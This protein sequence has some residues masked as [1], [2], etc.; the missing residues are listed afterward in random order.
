MHGSTTPVP[1]TRATYL[2][3]V[4]AP[5][6]GAL[7]LR[8]VE[9]LTEEYADPHA[10]PGA[11]AWQ[12]R[13]ETRALAAVDQLA[14]S[15]AVLATTTLDYTG[16][17]GGVATIGA[18]D[19]TKRLLM[20]IGHEIPDG[21]PL[22]GASFTYDMDP[23]SESYGALASVTT[24]AGGVATIAY[25]RPAL[26]L[27]LRDHAVTPPAEP[28]V[29]YT[30]P[31]LAFGDEYAVA[32]WRGSDGSV[33]ATAYR[34]EGR[35]LAS[36]VLAPPAADA[37]AYAALRIVCGRGCFA[38][39]GATSYTLFHADPGSPGAWVGSA[40]PEPFDLPA[41]APVS[42]AAGAG[43]VALLA[44]VAG[45]MLVRW[46]DG[47]E[48][49]TLR[50]PAPA[51]TK[52]AA[53]DGA[54]GLLVRVASTG[55]RD[56]ELLLVRPDPEAGWVARPFR[57]SESVA[58]LDTLAVAVGSTYAVVTLAG[59][60]D[61]DGT[62]VQAA[63]WWN[64]DGTRV[65]TAT[66]RRVAG[67]R[68]TVA[69]PQVRGATVLLDQDVFRFDGA[70]WR[71]QDLGALTHPGQQAVVALS[72]GAD[73]VA[74]AVR[75]GDGSLV[76]DLIAYDPADTG[77]TPW[78]YVPGMSG[79]PAKPGA[80]VDMTA[81]F[82]PGDPGAASRFVLFDNQLHV[83]SGDGTWPLLL[84]VPTRFT[85]E[86]IASFRLF[87]GY[88][89]YQTDAGVA[90]HP[91]RPGGLGT[92]ADVLLS[93]AKVLPPNGRPTAGE[94]AFAAYTGVWDG[95]HFTLR[96]YRPVAEDVRGALAPLVVSRL[97]LYGNGGPTQT[98]QLPYGAVPIAYEL[99]AATATA[100]GTGRVAAANRA[101]LAPGSAT[102]TD[103]GQGTATSWFFN[104]LSPS[105]PPDRPYP[106]GDDA[107][108]AAAHL[109]RLPGLPYAQAL[110]GAG[111]TA[112][113]LAGTTWWWVTTAA[114]GARTQA[115]YRRP[116]KE[117]RALDGVP[118]ERTFVYH[119]ETG[120]VTRVSGTLPDG[121]ATVTR[122]DY[123]W[124]HYD[125]SRARNL[126]TPVVQAMEDVDGTLVRGTVVT[127]S[128]DWGSGGGQWAPRAT[129]RAVTAQPAAF[130]RWTGDPLPA[131]AGWL[132]EECVAARSAGGIATRTSDALGRVG[133]SVASVDGMR[134]LAAFPN[135]DA[136]GQEAYWYGL[137]PY[138][139]PGPWSY[140]GGGTIAD[141]LVEGEANLGTRSL[142]I[143]YDT[144][145]RAG[146]VAAFQPTD[147]E[148]SYRFS[149]WVQT[150]PSFATDSGAAQLD[151]SAT[152]A[153]P[154][155]H[156]IGSLTVPFPATNGR[157]RYVTAV[158]PLGAWRAEQGVSPD[159]PATVTIAARNQKARTQILLDGL[160]FQPLDAG[161]FA[162]VPD[163]VTGLPL[164]S[165]ETNGATYRLI[166]DANRVVTATVGPDLTVARLAIPSF[167]RLL[168]PD[169]TYAEALPNAT[170][171][172]SA[173]SD[174]VYQNFE[175]SDAGDWTLP[176][177]WSI[178]DGQ[179]VFSGSAVEPPGSA[180][181]LKGFAHDD[182]VATAR[183]VP[184]ATGA[185]P[186]VGI[187]CGNVVALHRASGNDWVLLTRAPGQ[188]WVPSPALPGGL[189]RGDLTFS[190]VG[191]RV[192]V[193]A[194]GRQVFSRLI[195]E[196]VVPDGTLALYLDG[197]GAF[198]DLVALAEPDLRMVMA[199][200]RGLATQ[201]IDL[202]GA[203]VDAFGS[204]GDAVGR[205]A[206]DKNAASVKI[207]SLDER[208]VGAPDDYLPLYDGREQTLEEYLAHG[209][210]SPFVRK[211]HEASPLARLR[212][213]G[214]PGDEL[215]VGGGHSTALA[216]ARNTADGP[217]AGVLPPDTAGNQSLVTI[218]DPDNRDRYRLLA[219]DGRLVAERIPLG[220]TATMTTRHTYDAAGAL[221]ATTPPNGFADPARADAWQ[222]VYTRDF[223]GRATAITTPD[224]GTTR[225]GYDVLGRLRVEQSA[226]QAAATPPVIGYRRYDGLDRLVELG[227]VTGVGW[228]ASVAAVAG[229]PTW[230]GAGTGCKAALTLTYDADAEALGST[231]TEG[232]LV[233]GTRHGADGALA[234]RETS[235]YD[236]AGNV[237][238]RWTEAPGFDAVIRE[239]TFAYDSR[240]Y[241]VL[242]T[243]PKAAA[244]ASPPLTVMYTRDRQGRVVAVG[245]PPPSGFADPLN[246]PPDESA[247]YARFVYDAGG[248]LLTASYENDDPEHPPIVVRY[249]YDTAGWPLATASDV[250]AE[251]VSYFDGGYGGAGSYGGSVAAVA[252]AWQPE[253]DAPYPLLSYTARYAYDPAGRLVAAAPYLAPAATAGLADGSTPITVDPNGNLLTVR[254]GEAT[255]AYRYPQPSG[256]AEGRRPAA[257]SGAA[258]APSNC[259]K[260]VV[261][262]LATSCTFD[263]DP[264]SGWTYGASDAGPGCATVIEGGP[265][266]S[267]HCLRMTGDTLG[268]AAEL[269]YRGYVDPRGRYTMR[270][271]LK[272]DAGFAAAKGTAG[273]YVDLHGP[274]GTVASVLV[275]ELTAPPTAWAEQTVAFDLAAVYQAQG[276]YEQVVDVSFVL[277]TRKRDSAAGL[278]VDDL[279]LV[280]DG[281]TGA[282]EYDPSGRV[283]AIAN[284]GLSA[285]SYA[286]DSSTVV[287]Y[288][289]AVAGGCRIAL[290]LD[291]AGQPT[292]RTATP[293][294]PSGAEQVSL[295]LR[296]P[297]GELL[298]RL[299]RSGDAVVRRRYYIVGPQGALAI[300]DDEGLC[301]ILRGYDRSARAVT[302][303]RGALLDIYDDDAFGQLQKCPL[304]GPDLLDRLD[305]LSGLDLTNDTPYAPWLGRNLA[306][307]PARACPKG[308]P[309]RLGEQSWETW[310]TNQFPEGGVRIARFLWWSF[311]EGTA[312][313]RHSPLSWSARAIIGAGI[314]VGLAFL[315]GLGWIPLGIAGSVGA[316]LSLWGVASLDYMG[317]S[318]VAKACKLRDET[319]LG[320][321]PE[322][323]IEDVY[324]LLG[325]EAPLESL[326]GKRLRPGAVGQIPDG[327]YIFV[328]SE[329]G[330]FLYRD[331]SDRAGGT[332]LYVRHSMLNGGGCARTAGMMAIFE[333]EIIL[334][335][336]SGHYGPGLDTVEA[337]AVPLLRAAGYDRYRI[338]VCP[339][340][341]VDLKKIMRAFRRA[342]GNGA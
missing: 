258:V 85:D 213:L 292:V 157:W 307:P 79:V 325:Y 264:P 187:G 328:V 43:Y 167:A 287:A 181:T 270:Y 71:H 299:D 80:T 152:A 22:P 248:Q 320:V 94:T 178:A 131:S 62:V 173:G 239:S 54:N 45:T 113:E 315:P 86:T 165:L 235:G 337:V 57:L 18:G 184:P 280:G 61:G 308:V 75:L 92:D 240:G 130:D 171:E 279:T 296:T 29:T 324:D 268:T 150:A 329:R 154:S 185:A 339:F 273:W 340:E 214:M 3:G 236:V 293:A 122:L 14:P 234:V 207:R 257:A 74:R 128:D 25:T 271:R 89:V 176:G 210:G 275:Q 68:L 66:L 155:P 124:Q 330:D 251:Q 312:A 121:R 53:L 159:V 272:A 99:G 215:A 327:F 195:P 217:M 97:V 249:E 70:G 302:D 311:V 291:P 90:A 230:P 73:V 161:F 31:R 34:W 323:I 316:G 8:Y 58:G 245:T 78:S 332:E 110:A 244:D 162:E 50:C 209:R 310:F 203:A 151:V 39:A 336:S 223:L 295:F 175:E 278:E 33:A 15:G 88:L 199:D 259:L 114:V 158:I 289:T 118:T 256:P 204:V 208:I 263:A 16:P 132:L 231:C 274:G 317:R 186:S 303:D 120:L 17:G 87:P 137:E 255:S 139:D 246:P 197:P 168:T 220:G 253:A 179:L 41:D 60:S 335:N 28:G 193:F 63:L 65:Q 232:R 267:T 254:R 160:R 20:G 26:T 96:L 51:G 52:H 23:T 102:V 265:P 69:A 334:T 266:G 198:R 229:D 281:S 21:Y 205:P 116:R 13:F 44:S 7:A 38:I 105:E 189:G 156:P 6:G 201:A 322:A 180:A 333:G 290:M 166:R 126:L 342:N 10:G 250:Y 117:A 305:V 202:R 109:A 111:T 237:I 294:D 42:L 49:R 98:G 276:A 224:S 95:E 172:A 169:G 36:R 83:L 145:G 143:A 261:T 149:C 304:R 288:H 100:D 12:S 103:A 119:D 260:E 191:R 133:S 300:K 148:R 125:P 241:L 93:G 226:A 338:T 27:P 177:G 306:P 112:P 5:D 141:H 188:G 321:L 56:H 24:E 72:A 331:M 216:Y 182:Y 4:T 243:L 318:A 142:A 48:W 67:A 107:T 211:V 104:G 135:A 163:P 144:E 218:N 147:Q 55:G 76:H 219:P 192:T 153:T 134:Q 19:R 40:R 225:L 326:G 221:V 298:A 284:A 91:L 138:E 269:A 170:L 196:D 64:A 233:H 127:W 285:V 82:D 282:F 309:A 314:G 77:A 277:R 11:A 108:N 174:A 35:W 136:N 146:P 190:L 183:F 32:L 222:T 30:E 319:L 247:R 228:E 129:Y 115:A 297:D 81:R 123:W 200:G 212:G 283:T 262:T 46:F 106:T 164:G 313:M 1:Y 37:A 206:Y 341:S 59:S 301:Y 140:R 2:T 242:A 47:A 238:A 227:T 194:A 252:R 286:P 84:G 9:K 101:T